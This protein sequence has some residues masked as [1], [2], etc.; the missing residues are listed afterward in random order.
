MILPNPD[1]SSGHIAAP[2][3]NDNAAAPAPERAASSAGADAQKAELAALVSRA[4]AGDMAAQSELIRLYSRRLA[5]HIKAIVRRSDAV[6]DLTQTVLIKMVRRLPRLRDPALFE[7]WLFTMSR[8]VAFD[9][10]RSCH[11]RPSTTANEAVLSEL[12]DAQQTDFTREILDE[13]AVALAQVSPVD[14]R[15]MTRLVQGDNYRDLA[16]EHGLSTAAVKVRL[17]RMRP[18]LRS[19]LRDTAEMSLRDAARCRAASARIA[20]AA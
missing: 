16:A 10:I 11:R 9:Y 13:L 7:S 6:E 12:S 14:R 2:S 5:G 17:H 18:F 8:H 20:C 3:P 15:L 19:R 1:A 4:R